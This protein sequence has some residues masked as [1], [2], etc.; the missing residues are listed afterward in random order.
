M[1]DS[2]EHQVLWFDVDF[3]LFLGDHVDF[4]DIVY[5]KFGYSQLL[6]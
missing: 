5:T 2:L 1:N 4:N 6:K 3:Y